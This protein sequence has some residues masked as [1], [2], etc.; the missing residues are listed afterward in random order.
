MQNE[1]TW[2]RTR[3]ITKYDYVPYAPEEKRKAVL[4]RSIAASNRSLVVKGKF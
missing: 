2:F 1:D 4:D 3:E